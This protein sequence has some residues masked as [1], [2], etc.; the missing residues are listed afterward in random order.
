[1]GPPG[2]KLQLAVAHEHRVVPPVFP[3]RQS[4]HEQ[5]F[6]Q[7]CA[8]FKIDVRQQAAVRV[9]RALRFESESNNPAIDQFARERRGLIG[10]GLRGLIRER[11]MCRLRA[12]HADEPHACSGRLVDVIGDLHFDRVA[13]DDADH[14]GGDEVIRLAV[15]PIGQQPSRPVCGTQRRQRREQRERSSPADPAQPPGAAPAG[16]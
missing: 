2:G 8:V 13:V 14:V 4:L 7:A 6:G 11:W 1:M 9:A 12:I 16:K 15:G 5:L 10:E 3:P